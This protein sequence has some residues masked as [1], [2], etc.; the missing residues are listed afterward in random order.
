MK[1]F[2]KKSLKVFNQSADLAPSITQ[3]SEVKV[4]FMICFHIIELFESLTGS[5]FVYDMA[6]MHV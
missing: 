4:T 3:W 1:G 6:R 2:S 5:S